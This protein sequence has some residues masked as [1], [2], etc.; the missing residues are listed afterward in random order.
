MITVILNDKSVI[1]ID[2]CI[3]LQSTIDSMLKDAL[4][5][6][7]YDKQLTLD[8]NFTEF[9]YLWLCH[10]SGKVDAQRPVYIDEIKWKYI[11]LGKVYT[12]MD[13]ILYFTQTLIINGKFDTEYIANIQPL[14]KIND[15]F[16]KYTPFIW[17][18]KCGIFISYGN[19]GRG[20]IIIWAYD[21]GKCG[22]FKLDDLM[23]EDRLIR[24][25]ALYSSKYRKEFD[26]LLHDIKSKGQFKE[27]K[28]LE[29]AFLAQF[30]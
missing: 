12:Q 7:K 14:V 23:N 15:K 24:P 29:E 5:S 9:S 8:L 10:V 27:N 18:G 25:F 11:G 20:I 22:Y 17:N 2:E 6:C 28:Q 26:I 3:I 1:N 16:N 19:N 21:G 13:Y 4:E 30:D